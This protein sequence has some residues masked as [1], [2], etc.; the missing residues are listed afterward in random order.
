MKKIE[1]ADDEAGQKSDDGAPE[2]KQQ[3]PEQSSRLGSLR[4]QIEPHTDER[5]SDGDERQQPDQTIENHREQCARLFVWCLFEQKI[6]LYNIAAG[7][8]RQKL[9]VKHSN[10]RQTGNA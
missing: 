4:K 5:D 10:Q 8:T 6:A 7:S 9:I 2:Q 1:A 3:N